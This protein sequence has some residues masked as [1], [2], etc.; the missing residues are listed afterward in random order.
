MFNQYRSCLV[1]AD[2]LNETVTYL[3]S[4]DWIERY[5][6]FGFFVSQFYDLPKSWWLIVLPDSGRVI[7][8]NI[9]SVNKAMIFEVLTDLSDL[10]DEEGGLNAL[11]QVYIGANTVHTQKVA[12]A[13]T[14]SYTT[15]HGG[16][17]TQGIVTTFAAVNASA[18]RWTFLSG[19]TL[20]LGV[21]LSAVVL[22]AVWT[23][24]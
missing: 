1:V 10:L 8:I 6:W 14:K 17:P 21:V 2:F 22:G 15:I 13:P 3:D 9:V 23:I 24:L 18:R 5:A 4:L 7:S 20:R 19:E 11:G 12:G 16:N